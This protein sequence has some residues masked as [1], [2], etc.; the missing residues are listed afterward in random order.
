MPH[1]VVKMKAGRTEEMKRRL[2]DNLAQVVVSTLGCDE[3]VVSIAIVDVAPER[4]TAEVHEPEIASKL[5]TLYKKP[6]H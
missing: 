2:A 3:K 4:W 5:D 6:G 1:V